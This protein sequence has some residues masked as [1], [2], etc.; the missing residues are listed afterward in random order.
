PQRVMASSAVVPE[1]Q[2]W[3]AVC[4]QVLA[5]PVTTPCGHNFCQT[6]IRQRWDRS[7]VCQCPTC[8]RTF[9]SRPETSVNAAFKELTEAFR[10]LLVHPP[11]PPPPGAVVC[12]VCAAASLQVEAVKS[13][14]VCVTSYCQAHLEPHLRV[15]S[16]KLHKLMAPV[17]NLPERMCEKHERLLEVFCRDEQRCVCRFCTET[18][19]KHH[20]SVAVEDESAVRKVQIKQTLEEFQQMIQERLSKAE[21]IQNRLQLSAASAAE[22]LE[23]CDRLFESLIRSVQERRGDVRA[24]IRSRQKEAERRAESLIGQLQREAAELQRRTAGLEELLDTEDHLHL[25]QSTPLLMAPPAWGP[26]GQLSVH[27]QPCVGTARRALSEVE[28]TLAKEM[29]AL[30]K[31]EMRRMQKYAGDVVLDPDTAHPNILL[32]ADGKQAGRGEPLQTVPDHPKRFDPVICVVARTGFLSGRF[33]F[34][35]EVGAKT[36]WDLGVVRESAGRKGMITSTPENGFWTVRLRSGEE[37]RALDSPSVLLTLPKRPRVIG[38]FTDYEEGTVSFFD[39]EDQSHVYTF[40][41]CVFSE[42]ILPFL[43]PG[44]CDGGRNAAPLVITDPAHH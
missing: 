34:Q 7:Q 40:S 30:R 18:E 43:S 9:R 8:G 36:F 22:D 28:E 3:C 27:A 13:C 23:N 31:E 42:R 37:Y 41:G 2:F 21:E 1:E 19:H 39:A 15:G 11:A 29:D 35:V 38:V 44:V 4:Q 25:L 10:N 26:W 14:L 16:L 32:S 6:C 5:D 17:R 24:E 33:Y 20:H 12:D